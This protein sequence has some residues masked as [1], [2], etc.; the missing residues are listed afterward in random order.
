MKLIGGCVT[1]STWVFSI[2]KLFVINKTDTV[3]LMVILLT[4]NL[5]L[6]SSFNIATLSTFSLQ[7][8][9]PKRESQ[10]CFA[11]KSDEEQRIEFLK[12]LLWVCFFDSE[13]GSSMSV[14]NRPQNERNLFSWF[15]EG[16]LALRI[17]SERNPCFTYN[18]FLSLSYMN[19]TKTEILAENFKA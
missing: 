14:G 6:I 8:N 4:R 17:T 10:L 12:F 18:F 9:P 11:K 3:I 1:I 16:F 19:M 2:R 13:L 15:Y 7:N 5:E